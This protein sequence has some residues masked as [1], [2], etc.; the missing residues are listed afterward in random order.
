MTKTNYAKNK[1]FFTFNL[2]N[3]F[4][5]LCLSA[6]VFLIMVVIICNPSLFS[7][8]T[9]SGVK[10]FFFSVFPGL[11][12]FMFLTKILT[13]LGAVFKASKKLEPLS[14]KIFGTPGISFYAF[15]MSILSGYPIGAQIIGDLYSKN[16]ISQKD[17]HEMTLFC[18][19]SGPIF[20]IGAIGVGMLSSF[21]LGVIIYLSH[22]VS[23]FLIGIFFNLLSKKEP[24]KTQS[25]TLTQPKPN[26][27]ISMCLSETINS[28]LIVGGYITIFYLLSELLL[29]LGVFDLLTNL[30]CPLTNKL[31]FSKTE[32]KGILFGLVEITRGA[33][34]LSSMFRVKLLPIISGLVS[35]SGVSIIMQSMAFLK[36][37]KIKMHNFIFGKVVHSI[38]SI[39]LCQ[40]L[41][42][43]AV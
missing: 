42:I 37:T 5:D 35:F 19:T 31:G 32:T 18:T 38:L 22:I 24:S 23:S 20:V 30:I 26:G 11:F 9:I 10:L 29:T 17:A 28:I 33:K 4:K 15:F 3:D 2:S 40:I 7:S 14:Q 12:P 21:K 8:G 16:L 41:V 34:E 36:E 27:I 25:I 6:L 1:I 39:F 13:S 43:F